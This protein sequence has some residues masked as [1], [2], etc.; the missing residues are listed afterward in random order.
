MYVVQVKYENGEMK[1]AGK[2]RE[3]HAKKIW[4]GEQKSILVRRNHPRMA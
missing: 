2:V 1:W 3:F 4:N